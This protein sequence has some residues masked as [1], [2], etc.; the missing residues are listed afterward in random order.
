MNDHPVDIEISL[1]T[2]LELKLSANINASKFNR[3]RYKT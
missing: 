1:P 2:E 3:R